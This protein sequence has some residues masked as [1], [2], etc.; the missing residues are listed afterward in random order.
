ML[1]SLS[2]TKPVEKD[3]FEAQFVL[4]LPVAGHY[5]VLV[6]ASLLD[7]GGRVWH[8]GHQSK[9]VVVVESGG[10]DGQRSQ[11]QREPGGALGPSAAGSSAGGGGGGG[12][13]GGFSLSKN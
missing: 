4:E 2:R 13:K 8:T 3:Y 5:T 9:M 6:K 12:G 1:N 10:E 11:K 7:E